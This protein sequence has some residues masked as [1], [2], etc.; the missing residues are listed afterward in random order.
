MNSATAI[1]DSDRGDSRCRRALGSLNAGPENVAK[2]T[3]AGR[4]PVAPRC[5]KCG[6]QGDVL[7]E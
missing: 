5:P 6:G 1:D 4:R 7:P 2:E 3:P